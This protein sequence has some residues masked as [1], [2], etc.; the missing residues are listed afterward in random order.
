MDL[1]FW[2][3]RVLDVGLLGCLGW[4]F[5]S[6][7]TAKKHQARKAISLLNQIMQ[8]SWQEVSWLVILSQSPQDLGGFKSVETA[9]AEKLE[10]A[11]ASKALGAHAI[12]SS[13]VDVN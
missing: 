12:G 6:I 5:I 10:V 7:S 1:G 2:I 8:C 9:A 11:G 3:F 4:G 13:N